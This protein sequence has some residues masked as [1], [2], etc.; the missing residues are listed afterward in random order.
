MKV[1]RIGTRGHRI[2]MEGGDVKWDFPTEM[3]LIDLGTKVLLCDTHTGPQC[4]DKVRDFVKENLGL[5]EFMVFNSHPHWD[6][7][8]GNCAFQNDTIIIS[9]D[10]TYEIMK[11]IMEYQF[12]ITSAFIEEGVRP[13]LPNM[14]FSER[15]ALPEFGIEFFHA[16]GHTMGCACLHDKIDN[17]VFVGDIIE[18]PM[19][20]M[21]SHRV[22][23]YSQTLQHLLNS[24]FKFY[25]TS[26]SGTVNKEQ[27]RDNLNYINS[28]LEKHSE[29]KIP[30]GLKGAHETNLKVIKVSF[31]EEKIR[32]VLGK[33][34]SLSDFLSNIDWSKSSVELE[35][36]LK[37][38][39]DE[40]KKK[41]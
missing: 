3:Y 10:K 7:V 41:T 38:L 4:I 32:Q 37:T 19:P 35:E 11:E 15:M 6:H 36:S 13:R 21:D 27:I 24:D 23:L 17:A 9:S 39:Y 14:T 20:C 25:V 33:Y 1:Y 29:H 34:F 16:P 26:H 28:F 30:N 8:A 40:H 22:D 2:L 31:W 5:R 18:H 12:S